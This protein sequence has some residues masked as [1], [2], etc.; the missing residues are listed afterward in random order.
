MADMLK[1]RAFSG[2]ATIQP[3]GPAK[4]QDLFDALII[5]ANNHRAFKTASARELRPRGSIQ[6]ID[7]FLLVCI[8]N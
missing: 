3:P 4:E 6:S 1:E 7:Y 2:A 5:Q 8:G